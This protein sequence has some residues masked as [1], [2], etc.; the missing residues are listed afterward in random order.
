MILG[1]TEIQK[2]IKSHKLLENLSDREKNEP[3]AVVKDK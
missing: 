2:L 1:Q 3:E